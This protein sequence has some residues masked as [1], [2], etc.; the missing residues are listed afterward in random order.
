MVG[1]GANGTLTADEVDA[2]R[3]VIGAASI[4]LAQF[5][6]PLPAVVAGLKQAKLLGIAVCLNPSPWRD[7]FP[8][9]DIALDFVIV[10]EHEASS[11]LGRE[12][13][14]PG[15][16]SSIG[17]QLQS[18]KIGTLIVTRGAASTVVFSVEGDAMEVPVLAVDPVDTVGAGDC[19]AGVFAARWS[20]S[21]EVGTA[22][23]AASVAG[24]LATLKAG[25]QEA[26]PSRDQV[27]A[28]MELLAKH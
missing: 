13:F 28:G 2:R 11:L 1:A 6:V 8:W 3:A 26:T 12:R 9:G 24:S 20:R 21:G 18:L 10:N 14:T 19:F 23:R 4:L 22:L 7:D 5:E 27:D 17:G 25:A 15:D 16:A